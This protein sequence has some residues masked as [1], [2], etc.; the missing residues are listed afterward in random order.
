[1]Q[2]ETQQ[3]HPSSSPGPLWDIPLALLAAQE[4]RKGGKQMVN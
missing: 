1:M 4:Q 2:A 3:T